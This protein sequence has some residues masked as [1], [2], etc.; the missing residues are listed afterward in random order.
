MSDETPTF[1]AVIGQIEGTHKLEHPTMDEDIGDGATAHTAV[2]AA[3]DA[4]DNFTKNRLSATAAKH[5]SLAHQV[6]ECKA[7]L[8]SLAF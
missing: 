7:E 5:E 6:E 8:I 2:L 4:G 1:D 3:P